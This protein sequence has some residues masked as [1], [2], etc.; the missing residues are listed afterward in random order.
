MHELTVTQSVLDIACKHAE[1]AHAKAVTDIYLV[2]GRLS[3][4][5]DDSVQFYWD[6]ISKGTLCEHAQLHFQRKPAILVC[7]ECKNEY[8]LDDNLTP[9]PQCGSANVRVLS[10]DE[11]NLESIEISR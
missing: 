10:G 2:I 11:F 4:I 8:T 7:L 9:C 3:S 6:F 5:V 1:K